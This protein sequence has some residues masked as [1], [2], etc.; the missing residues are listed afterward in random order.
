MHGEDLKMFNE[1]KD[2]MSHRQKVRCH[3]CD[4]TEVEP[5]KII[6]GPIDPITLLLRCEE[7]EFE[8]HGEFI[9]WDSKP[10]PD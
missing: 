2:K 6:T 3:L 8:W 9:Y 1:K 10:V 7:C 4:S 5:V